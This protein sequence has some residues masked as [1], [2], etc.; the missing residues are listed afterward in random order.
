MSDKPIV[1]WAA[2]D[3]DEIRAFYTQR[4][5]NEDPGEVIGDTG[6]LKS[7]RLGE[8]HVWN[9]DRTGQPERIRRASK[10]ACCL[11]AQREVSPLS[12]KTSIGAFNF[13]CL[14]FLQHNIEW[15]DDCRIYDRDAAERPMV[16]MSVNAV[17]AFLNWL[18]DCGVDGKNMALVLQRFRSKFQY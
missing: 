18:T 17:H 14:D 6:G 10:I 9:T 12:V 13:A 11:L 1:T 5:S 15:F 3:P 2:C 7:A 16:E 4:Y 8:F